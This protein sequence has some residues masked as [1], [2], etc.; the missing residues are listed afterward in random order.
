M[1]INLITA[2]SA[3]PA[4]VADYEQQNALTAALA[5][6][7]QGAAR[8][9]GSNVVKGAIFLVGGALYLT[10]A[11]TAISGSASDYV[12]LTVSGTTLVPSFVADLTGVTWSSTWNGYYDASGNLYEFDE[13]S[14]Y[15]SGSI[16]AA[17]T[18]EGK[19][20]LAR[21][22]KRFSASGSFRAP[23]GV[24][25]VYIT[26]CA[27][28]G[29]GASGAS[30]G[31]GGGGGGGGEWAIKESFATVP[32]TLYTVTIGAVGSNTSIGTFVL[33]HGNNASGA[34][35]GL[36]TSN[37]HGTGSGGAGGNGGAATAAGTSGGSGLSR[38]GGG[39]TATSSTGGG[40]GG[41]GGGYRENGDNGGNAVGNGGT[42]Y[43]GGGGGGSGTTGTGGGGGNGGYG[44]G[45]GGG[46]GTG[47]GS[48]AGGAGGAGGPAF[49]I[50]E[51]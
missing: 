25:T 12:K 38:G 45:G 48:S 7:A 50:V 51:W 30:A 3:V 26:G 18:T 24:S 37:S 22:I 29:N 14:A 39:G 8:V 40:G 36:E 27:A 42:G 28:G 15:I 49:L 41:G 13:A 43:S 33:T 46:G 34:T 19:A 16:S 47:S 1:A 11:D 9:L 44:G 2:P 4:A 10:D 21:G 31:A 20:K 23:P 17:Y 5:L 6:A 35:G 32:G